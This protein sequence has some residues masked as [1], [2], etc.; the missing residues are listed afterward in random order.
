MEILSILLRNNI[1]DFDITTACLEA[2]LR[3][4]PNHNFDFEPFFHEHGPILRFFSKTCAN[5][6]LTLVKR[7]ADEFN[8]T[9]KDIRARNNYALCWSCINGHLHV[10][11]WLTERFNLT[12]NDARVNNNYTLRHSCKNGHFLCRI[13]NQEEKYDNFLKLKLCF[14]I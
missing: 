5:G 13:L 9:I 14:S 8:L 4:Y 3:S 12:I 11:Q 10:A 7:L 6:H 2:I 1:L